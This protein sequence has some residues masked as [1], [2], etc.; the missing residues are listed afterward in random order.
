MAQVVVNPT[1]I[2][3]WPW[4][5]PF[6]NKNYHFGLLVMSHITFL[7]FLR[8]HRYVIF[9]LTQVCYFYTYTGMLFL[10]LH[11]YVIFTLTQVCYF[12]T[13]TGM[14]FL[15]LHRYVIFTLTQVCYFFWFSFTFFCPLDKYKVQYMHV[16][17][18]KC[19]FEGK[20]NFIIFYTW[21]QIKL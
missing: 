10:H 15:H 7:V 17:W 19:E 18:S 1:T 16:S 9:T 8:L 13:Y 11:R 3:S 5:P 21:Q 20:I 4:R 6:Q 14:L 2:R 12:Y